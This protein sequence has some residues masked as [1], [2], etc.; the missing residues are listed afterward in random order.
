MATLVCPKHITDIF[1]GGKASREEKFRAHDLVLAWVKSQLPKIGP[2][3]TIMIP[4]PD[5]G[6]LEPW[7][8]DD[9]PMQQ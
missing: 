6:E 7:N 8:Q 3:D 4:H 1:K 5:T 2:R 9:K